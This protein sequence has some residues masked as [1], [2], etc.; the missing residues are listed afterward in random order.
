MAARNETWISVFFNGYRTSAPRR[1]T[2]PPSFHFSC[3]IRQVAILLT[4]L[5]DEQI[6]RLNIHNSCPVST[7]SGPPPDNKGAQSDPISLS[8]TGKHNAV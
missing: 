2:F 7:S 8:P 4:P 5:P 6:N 3:I 1:I